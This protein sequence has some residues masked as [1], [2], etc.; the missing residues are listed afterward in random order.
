MKTSLTNHKNIP[1]PELK[2]GIMCSGSSLQKWQA[3]AVRYLLDY[4][5][6]CTML[7]VDDNEEPAVSMFRKIKRYLDPGGFYRFYRR[8][9]FRPEALK[10]VAMDSIPGLKEVKTIR[11]K[12]VRKGYSEYFTPDDIE[13]IREQQLD[14]ILRFGFN[15]IRG[16]ILRAAKYGVWSFHHDDEQKYRGGPPGFRE[17]LHKDAVTGAILQRLTEKLDGG[18]VLKKGFYPTVAHSWEGQINLLYFRSAEWPLL[19]CKDILN[20][21]A[22]YLDEPPGKTSAKIFKAPRNGE[23]LR[24]AFR[25]LKN[26]V[27]FHYRELFRPED[28]NVGIA[29]VISDGMTGSVGEH[30][31]WLPP[32]PK[33]RYYADPFAFLSDGRL[34]VLFENYDYRFRK[35]KI[36]RVVF[37]KGKISAAETVLEEPFHLSYPFVT[38]Y[39]G[40]I[41]C[42]P[43]AA[44]SGGIRLYRF[45]KGK[46]RF[47][48]EKVL[49]DG[50]P[51]VDPTIFQY[52]DKWWLFA[53]DKSQ[54]NTDLHVFYAYDLFGPYHPHAGNPVKIDIRNARPAGTPYWN[55]G[56]LIRPAQDCSQTYGG[57]TVLNSIAELTENRFSEEAA[58]YIEPLSGSRYSKG[59]HTF[60]LVGGYTI[61]DGKKFKF[62]RHHFRWMLKKKLF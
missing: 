62:N 13:V 27:A 2:F 38:G 50:F 40:E 56:C 45:D 46:N 58:G 39:K 35:G 52:E 20:G 24:F 31:V 9:F 53:T 32:P 41:Y 57:R 36:S 51:G 49:V 5:L 47:L 15:I 22:G 42:V 61:F 48:F 33:G 29:E 18:I 19:V 23:M 11:C 7:I 3:G 4:G 12:T 28:W 6:S 55:N 16:D 17:I 1:S 34:H 44:D 26:K 30:A 8:F 10:P 54:S 60:S 37:H 59:L 25:L 21:N 14:F 43:E